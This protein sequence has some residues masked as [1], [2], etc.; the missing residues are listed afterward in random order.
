MKWTTKVRSDAS[1]H[2]PWGNHASELI[3]YQGFS[4]EVWCRDGGIIPQFS[5]HRGGKDHRKP[6]R[7]RNGPNACLLS[8]A[9]EHHH[10]YSGS[11]ASPSYYCNYWTSFHHRLPSSCVHMCWKRNNL[12]WIQGCSRIMKLRPTHFTHELMLRLKTWLCLNKEWVAG[13]IC[14]LVH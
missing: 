5:H 6:Q 11:S 9:R 10:L 3:E 12:K 4:T 8:T 14:M 7:H 13:F 1:T 2:F